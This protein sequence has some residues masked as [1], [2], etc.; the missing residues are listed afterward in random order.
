MEC[1]RWV[2]GSGS[3][4]VL[5]TEAGEVLMFDV[6]LLSRGPLWSVKAHDKVMKWMREPKFVVFTFF[7][8]LF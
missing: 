5:S 8:F 2:P 1:L 7:V 6:A 4:L 3:L